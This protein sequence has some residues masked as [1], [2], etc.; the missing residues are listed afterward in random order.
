MAVDGL[1]TIPSSNTVKATLDRLESEVKAR[2]IAIFARI[3]TRRGR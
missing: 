3:I 1:I 2:G